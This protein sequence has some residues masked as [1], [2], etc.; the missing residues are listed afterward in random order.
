MMQLISLIIVF[1]FAQE[2]FEGKV[3]KVSDGDTINV[4]TG[5]NQTIRVRFNGV[6]APEV[7]HSSGEPSQPYGQKARE[8]VVNYCAGKMVKVIIRDTDRYGRTIGDV[9]LV[10]ESISLNERLVQEGWAWHYKQ[11]SDDPT[12]AALEISAKNRKAGLWA[13]PNPVAPWEWRKQLKEA[14]TK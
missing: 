14:N 12:L 9:F 3:I 11:Y 1:F 2:S 7:S 5:D 6:D 10:G 13:D 8:F 4:L